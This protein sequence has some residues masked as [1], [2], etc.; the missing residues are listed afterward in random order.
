[1]GHGR[2]LTV[3]LAAGNTTGYEAANDDA[4]SA[5]R[6]AHGPAD[7]GTTAASRGI[8]DDDGAALHH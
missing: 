8:L 2:S 6:G 5:A 3:D 7:T 4:R 1:M